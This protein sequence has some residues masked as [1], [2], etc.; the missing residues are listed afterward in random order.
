[1]TAFGSH[2]GTRTL[3]GLHGS[4]CSDWTQQLPVLL[5][6]R[7]TCPLC[8][9]QRGRGNPCKAHNDTKLEAVF[10]RRCCTPPTLSA[11]RSLLLMN[12][13]KS[14]P[15]HA[16][17]AGSTL[18]VNQ[19]C[20]CR[21]ADSIPRTRA[22]RLLPSARVTNTTCNPAPPHPLRGARWPSA[23]RLLCPAVNCG[24]SPPCLGTHHRN[25]SRRR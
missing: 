19:N 8:W 15:F 3:T 12:S 5:R 18:R 14:K 16:A 13:K 4:A 10:W 25:R 24:A 20:G 2:W 23:A 9:M 21:T 6:A 17:C 11:N 1:M 22:S 7:Y